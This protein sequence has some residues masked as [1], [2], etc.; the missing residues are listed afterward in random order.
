M[1]LEDAAFAMAVGLVGEM[2]KT[3]DTRYIVEDKIDPIFKALKE[4][5]PERY[6]KEIAIYFG[7]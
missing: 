4:A 6:Q 7:K 5:N 3:D 1:T 2:T